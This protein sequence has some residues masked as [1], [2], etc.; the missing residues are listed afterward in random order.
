M[1]LRGRADR[2]ALVNLLLVQLEFGV[3]ESWNNETW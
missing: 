1:V 3:D 2:L